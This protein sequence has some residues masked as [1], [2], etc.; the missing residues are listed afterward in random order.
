MMKFTLTI[1][2]VAHGLFASSLASATSLQCP[3]GPTQEEVVRSAVAAGDDHAR[4]LRRTDTG[5]FRAD[6]VGFVCA[7]EF[8]QAERSHSRLS[9]IAR[10]TAKGCPRATQPAVPAKV[11]KAPVN[12]LPSLKVAS[13]AVPNR[14]S[15]KR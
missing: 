3:T 7:F 5:Q 13:V 6:Y 9:E 2:I 1:A 4:C 14:A 12:L 11:S 15:N 10:D 8:R